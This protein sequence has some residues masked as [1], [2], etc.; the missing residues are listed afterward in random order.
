MAVLGFVPFQQVAVHGQIGTLVLALLTC[1]F[2]A[3]RR[4]RWFWAGAACGA[5]LFKPQFGVAAILLVLA[6]RR[7]AVLTGVCAGALAVAGSSALALGIRPWLEYGRTLPVVWN[8]ASL[9]EPKL[10]QMHNVKGFC[11]LIAGAGIVGRVGTI[12]V[13][14]VVLVLVLRI[15]HRTESVELQTATLVLGTALLNPHLYIYDVVVVGLA[16]ATAAAW[17]LDH[18]ERGESP[19]ILVTSHTLCWIALLAP[20]AAITHVQLTAPLMVG[21]VFAINSSTTRTGPAVDAPPCS[22]LESRTPVPGS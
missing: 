22:A 17:A 15:W 9:F 21:M 1:M 6:S 3:L 12:L 14:V 19:I 8:A 11:E 18:P 10:W 7:F 16:L 5:L 2:L 13:S 20:L 4:G